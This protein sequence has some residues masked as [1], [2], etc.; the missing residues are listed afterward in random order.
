L[1]FPFH[2]SLFHQEKIL[3]KVGGGWHANKSRNHFLTGL[4]VF[5]NAGKW[6]Q[7]IGQDIDS[8]LSFYR[9]NRWSF[10]CLQ[11]LILVHGKGVQVF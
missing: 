10:A 3:A 1:S 8:D 7:K 2:F 4:S 6:Y 9:K 11:N 5:K